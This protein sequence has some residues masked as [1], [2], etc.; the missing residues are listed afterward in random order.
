MTLGAQM[1]GAPFPGSGQVLRLGDKQLRGLKVRLAR[2]DAGIL[3]GR[4]IEILC[5]C[6]Y[7]RLY[8]YL[9]LRLSWVLWLVRDG[10]TRD[11][12]MADVTGFPLL[13]CHLSHSR[14]RLAREQALTGL[15]SWYLREGG[16]RRV[17]KL[18]RF[19]RLFTRPPRILAVLLCRDLRF[20]SG[21]RA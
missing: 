16:L 9:R 1:L 21:L 11:I 10:L 18:V 13:G 8:L 15:Q 5:L 7:L 4:L 12:E 20:Y 6:L 17:V 3:V 2:K 14:L 19:Q